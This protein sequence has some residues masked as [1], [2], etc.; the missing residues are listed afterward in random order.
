MRFLIIL[1]FAI[2]LTVSVAGAAPVPTSEAE[3]IRETGQLVRFSLTER[4]M[5]NVQWNR[6]T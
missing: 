6:G 4:V 5:T 2:T 1:M 3:Q